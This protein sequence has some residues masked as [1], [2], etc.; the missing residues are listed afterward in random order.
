LGDLAGKPVLVDPEVFLAGYINYDFPISVDE[1]MT[2][3]RHAP[4]A[5]AKARVQESMN[6]KLSPAQ[7]LALSK[8]ET[9]FDLWERMI[10]GVKDEAYLL[11]ILGSSD[12]KKVAVVAS[13]PTG[14]AL[15]P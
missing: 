7:M 6:P 3:Y 10:G 1:Y 15:S 14:G 13:N 5:A 4:N 9:N 11:E 8:E 12:P 2:M